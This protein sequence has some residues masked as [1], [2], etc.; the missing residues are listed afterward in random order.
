MP[1]TTQNETHA[2]CDERLSHEGGKATCCYCRPH[3]GCTLGMK[4]TQN[5]EEWF[6]EMFVYGDKWRT[7]ADGNSPS[8]YGPKHIKAFIRR[9]LADARREGYEEG[10]ADQKKRLIPPILDDEWVVSTTMTNGKKI[11]SQ[12][13][14]MKD[15]ALVQLGYLLERM[16]KELSYDLEKYLTTLKEEKI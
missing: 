13:L 3:E 9:E 10:K 4:T 6:D 1:N 11:I 8:Q 15:R 12:R 5:W 7:F 14:T 16:N 2:V